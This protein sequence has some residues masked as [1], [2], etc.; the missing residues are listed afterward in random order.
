MRALQLTIDDQKNKKIVETLIVPGVLIATVIVFQDAEWD[1]R[2][3]F[4]PAVIYMILNWSI[5]KEFQRLTP[6]PLEVIERNKRPKAWVY[7]SSSILIVVAFVS[8]LSGFNIMN[9]IE[10]EFIYYL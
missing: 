8:S 2:W 4:F 10:M 7:L 1:V 6:K 5:F 3:A 9:C